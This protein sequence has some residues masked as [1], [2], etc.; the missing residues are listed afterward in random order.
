MFSRSAAVAVVAE[1]VGARGTS[2]YITHV[3]EAGLMTSELSRSYR[4]PAVEALGA[5]SSFA[6]LPSYSQSYAD[7]HQA[8]TSKTPKQ[9]SLTSRL[10]HWRKAV[11]ELSSCGP[12][13]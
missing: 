3:D 13:Q 5:Y 12:E 10:G 7:T 4:E 6:K 8:R 1:V 11:E 2:W 9:P